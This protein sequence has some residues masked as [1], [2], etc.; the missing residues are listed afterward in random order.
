MP[1]SASPAPRSP[2][3]AIRRLAENPSAIPARAPSPPSQT[4]DRI[5][6][7]IAVRLVRCVPGGA[8]EGPARAVVCSGLDM[9]YSSILRL[10]ARGDNAALHRRDA[11]PALGGS[12]AAGGE[13]LRN[14]FPR[15]LSPA[16]IP[17]IKGSSL[18]A[19]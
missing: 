1:A 13:C 5:S 14:F 11:Y 6:D 12:C 19:G 15:G 4:I 17:T 18:T 10:S 16:K 9:V 3:S 2:V 8:Y 7:Q